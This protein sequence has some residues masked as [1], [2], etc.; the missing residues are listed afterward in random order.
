MPYEDEVESG[1]MSVLAKGHQEFLVISWSYRETR[2]DP[3]QSLWR[4]HSLAQPTSIFQ[5]FSFQNCEFLLLI[6]I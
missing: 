2:E 6:A 4:E 5:I 3:P 1:V